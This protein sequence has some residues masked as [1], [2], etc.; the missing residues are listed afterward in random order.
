MKY[1]F[2]AMKLPKLIDDLLRDLGRRPERPTP[3]S[4]ILPVAREIEPFLDG[5]RY[6]G[7]RYMR[8]PVYLARD[9]EV[10]L[11][12]WE[13]GQKTPIHDHRGVT[14]SMLVFSG[15]LIEE[16]F[17]TPGG[18][19]ELL[20]RAERA[21]GDTCLTSPTLLHRLF[22]R[23]GRSLSLHIYRPPLREMGIWETDGMK[24]VRPSDYDLPADV[25]SPAEAG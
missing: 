10:M 21:S 13:S 4:V 22:P 2:G 12:S 23:R 9:W 15:G 16:T 20:E 8:H 7:E 6:S 18:K 17:E 25:L 3:G 19:P 14:G 1:T 11:I 5:V 24:E